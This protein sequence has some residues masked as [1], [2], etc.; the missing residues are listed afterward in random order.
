MGIEQFREKSTQMRDRRSPVLGYKPATHVEF[1]IVERI[2]T[3]ALGKQSHT[4]QF[5]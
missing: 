5:L 4:T 3:F 2:L 1:R